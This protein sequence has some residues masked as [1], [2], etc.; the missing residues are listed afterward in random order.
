MFVR[1]QKIETVFGDILT[2]MSVCENMIN[3]YEGHLVHVTKA[4][5][6]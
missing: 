4:H 2:V 6:I 1:G 3:T 5:A